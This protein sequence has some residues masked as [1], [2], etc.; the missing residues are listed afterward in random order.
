MLP[1]TVEHG[2]RRYKVLLGLDALA[3][4]AEVETA[5]TDVE[6]LEFFDRYRREILERAAAAI[7]N[8]EATPDGR[9]YLDTSHF[10]DHRR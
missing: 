3:D 4:L 7:A 2:G 10:L 1:F 5:N 8:G 6:C 9:V